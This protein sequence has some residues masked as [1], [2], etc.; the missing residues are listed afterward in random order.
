M[1]FFENSVFGEDS[2]GLVEDVPGKTLLFLKF[3]I[4]DV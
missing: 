2:S 4:L 1:R 3:F